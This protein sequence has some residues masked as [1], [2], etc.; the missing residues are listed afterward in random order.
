MDSVPEGSADRQRCGEDGCPAPL[1]GGDEEHAVCWCGHVTRRLD[2]TVLPWWL[3]YASEF[4]GEDDRRVP[5]RMKRDPSV[6]GGYA[7][8]LDS[9]GNAISRAKRHPNLGAPT[10]KREDVL[11]SLATLGMKYLDGH[12]MLAANDVHEKELAE[13]AVTSAKAIEKRRSRFRPTI[14]MDEIRQRMID[15]RT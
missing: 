1:L 6:P 13:A 9:S 15:L 3:S 8:R 2:G 11:D 14:A 7:L 12:P 5:L 4:Y 10:K